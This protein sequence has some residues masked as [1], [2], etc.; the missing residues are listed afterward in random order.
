MI[1][2]DDVQEATGALQLCAGQEAG[3][4]A[5]IHAM[6]ELFELPDTDAAILVDATNAFN[7]LNRENA[8]RNIQHL[9]PSI[10]IALINTY[11]DNV[12]LF[13][14]GQTLSST[15]GTTQGD[16][17]AMAMCALGVL[18][19]IHSLSS[20][21]IKQVWYADDATASGELAKIRSWWERLVEIGPQYG[22]FPNASKT[23]MVGKI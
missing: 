17:L 11:H 21:A 20:N 14:D 5:A 16:P 18:P 8:L 3:C 2:R 1:T 15:E 7:S 10:S 6:H 4:E 9:C 12:S 23:W 22:Y 19:L 13:I